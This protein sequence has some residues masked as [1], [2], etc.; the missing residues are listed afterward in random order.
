MAE[1]EVL[2]EERDSIAIVTL[3]RPDKMNTLTAAMIDGVGE[4]IDRATASREVRAVVLR[5][6]GRALTGGRAA[7]QP[8]WPPS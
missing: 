7:G 2:Y 6:A 4:A 1:S 3:N 5:G 8:I